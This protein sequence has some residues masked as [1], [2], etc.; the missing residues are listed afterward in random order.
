MLASTPMLIV[1]QERLP[2]SDLKELIA[3]LKANP[4]K[5]SRR[6]P[7]GRQP[8]PCRGVY[9]QKETG[10][11]FQFVPYRGAAPAMQDLVAGQIDLM[12]DQASNSLPQVQGGKIKAYAV[13]AKTRLAGGARHSDRRRGGAAR[14]ST[15]RSGTRCGRRRARRRTSSPSSMPPCVEAL[16][17]PAVRKRLT[18]LGQE[19][20][21]REQQT[22]EALAAYHKAEIEKWW[23]IIKAAASRRS[24]LRRPH[25]CRER[26][27]RTHEQRLWLAAA[28]RHV[29]GH[30]RRARA[31]L[32]VAA[33]HA[34]RA[35]SAGRA[36]RRDRAHPG[37]AHAGLARPADRRSRTSRGAGGTI[38]VGRVARAA[39]D[40]Y[41]IGIGHWDTHV[42]NGAI[43]PLP[44][45]LLKDFEPIALIVDQRRMLIVGRKTLPAN[46]LQGADR[47]AEGQSRTRR[48]QGIA[49]TGGAGARRR[50]LLPEGDRHALPVRALSRRRARRCRICSPGRSTS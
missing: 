3:W 39:P 12:F 1:A 50:R 25:E 14:A 36:D 26:R 42:V 30:R 16:A 15:S 41:T 49:G 8:P 37:R 21:P 9:F 22:P 23:P 24:E 44:Y 18:E 17:D 10:T 2:A 11:R 48:T 45:D 19:I 6:R 28:L 31:D 4:D 47:L 46:D 38:G 35:V 33:D 13:T 34:D 32:S 20:P 27:E 43:Y 5:A 29:G 7:R 40:G